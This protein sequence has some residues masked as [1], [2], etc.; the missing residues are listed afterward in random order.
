MSRH[1]ADLLS[2]L[3][4]FYFGSNPQVFVGSDECTIQLFTT[5]PD[6]IE[7]VLPPLIATGTTVVVSASGQTAVVPLVLPPEVV[8]Y[9]CQPEDG[10]GKC[11]TTGGYPV[12][13]FG[14]HFGDDASFIAVTIGVRFPI[15]WSC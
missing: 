4:G 6:V 9:D 8:S 14:S 2:A 10:S 12:S 11:S 13:L 7:C 3:Q 5:E 15:G 1:S